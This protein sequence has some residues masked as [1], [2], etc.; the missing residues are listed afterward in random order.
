MSAKALLQMPGVLVDWAK[1]TF[2]EW[3][4][5]GYPPEVAQRIVDG[6]LPMDEASRWQRSIDQQYMEDP[7][8]RGHGPEGISSNR[9]WWASSSYDV[10]E[11]YQKNLQSNY[12]EMLEDDLYDFTSVLTELD[13][14]SSAEINGVLYDYDW[15]SEMVGDTD[16]MDGALDYAHSTKPY[17]DD[18]SME[19]QRAEG[20]MRRVAQDG[21]HLKSQIT[22]IRTNATNL[23]EVNAGGKGWSSVQTNSNKLKGLQASPESKGVFR[24]TDDIADAVKNSG[25]YQGTRF[26]N[27]SDEAISI[28]KEKRGDSYNI[29]ASRPDVNIRSVHAAYDPKYTGSNIMGGALTGAVG[30]GALSQSDDADAMPALTL[31]KGI[32]AGLAARQLRNKINKERS[33][34]ISGEKSVADYIHRN[35]NYENGFIN[36]ARKWDKGLNG[37]S[38]TTGVNTMADDLIAGTDDPMVRD[39][40]EEWRASRLNAERHNKYGRGG[41]IAAPAGVLAAGARA[42]DEPRS[43]QEAGFPEWPEYKDPNAPLPTPTG[44]DI[45][46]SVTNV[47]GMP[48]A[49]LQGLA[50]GA[51]GLLSGEDLATAGAEAAH[52]MGSEYKDGFMTPGY[53]TDEGWQR[54][55]ALTER[56]F[57]DAGVDERVARG[58]GLFNQY[59][60]QLF[61]PF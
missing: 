8:Y 24:G 13:D 61:M 1:T 3:V 34:G 57:A 12:N 44:W 16:F 30:L 38:Y 51:Y 10:A 23:A 41:M 20:V 19:A 42:E 49:G 22:P 26:K 35:T 7:L 28:P 17:L 14:P 32:D 60:P 4:E 54:Y 33:K 55:G 53:D 6:E 45:V 27:I 2:D 5:A 52:M 37:E 29:L 43:A 11:T 31:M 9:D 50:R 25:S 39:A 18:L 59:V 56:T 48:M 40:V 36:G 15:L 47:L 58:L 21:T 46:D